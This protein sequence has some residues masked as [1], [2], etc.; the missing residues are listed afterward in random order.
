M[1]RTPREK[2]EEREES[3]LG[4][5]AVKSS[6]HGGRAR[7]EKSCPVRTAFQVDC[8]R[9]VHSKAFRRLKGKTQVFLW[10]EGD[11][12]RTRLTHCQEVSQIAR[13]LARAMDL[14]EDLAEV[15]SLAHDLGHTPFGHAGEE[16]MQKLV[17]GG[18]RHEQQSL[19]V[20][21]RLENEG[22]GL[23]LTEEVRDGILRHSKGAGPFLGVP[24]EM[25][26][27]TLEGQVVRLA[28]V[29][30]YANHDLDDALRAGV[31]DQGDLPPSVEEVLGKNHSA[32]LT[33]LVLDITEHT[34]LQKE[35]RITMGVEAAGAL[36]E[37][38]AFLY[39]NVYYNDR[40]HSEFHKASAL[41]EQLWNYFI[42]DMD[43]FYENHWPS[44][45]RDGAPEDDVRDFLAGM[46]DAFAV[47]LHER[48]F[49]PRRWYAP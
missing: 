33:R 12:Y 22:R 47:N 7:F 10:P 1:S 35:R 9:V 38:R 46:T 27:R 41:I 5:F 37:L 8:H 39:K 17:P 36:E 30:A 16:V 2:A 13:T 23:N 24:D 3:I 48:V 43:R 28:D 25:L 32:R 34:D 40:V 4:P 44:A 45:L 15:I 31:I 20:V 29:V 49:M 42:E 6:S 14:N 18:F 11:H 26:P 19:R 21:K